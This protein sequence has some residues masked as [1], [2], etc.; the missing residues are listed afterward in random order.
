M[1]VDSDR[2]DEKLIA[3]DHQST[4]LPVLKDDHQS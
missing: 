3:H 4:N 2:A 1:T